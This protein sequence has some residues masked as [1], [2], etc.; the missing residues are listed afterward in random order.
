MINVII[1]DT[2][3]FK[4]QIKA[5]FKRLRIHIGIKNSILLVIPYAIQ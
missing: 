2:F 3:K 4:I 5:H 1:P